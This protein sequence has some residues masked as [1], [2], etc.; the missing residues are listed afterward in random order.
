MIVL[1]QYTLC[2]SLTVL[3]TS[4]YL[5]KLSEKNFVAYF[6]GHPVYTDI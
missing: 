1:S 6:M 3:D 2:L 5:I 4:Q